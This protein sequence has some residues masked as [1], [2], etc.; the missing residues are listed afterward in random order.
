MSALVIKNLPEGLHS[1]LKARA[2]RNHRS[3]TRE[4]IAVLEAGV[5]E[6]AAS[7]SSSGEYPD[8]LDALAKAG[9][10]AME[11]GVNLKAW[12][13]RSREVWR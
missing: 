1:R 13:K 2:K 3:L 7:P 11:Q 9:K 10:A 4:A 5:N 6:T 8:P 12:A